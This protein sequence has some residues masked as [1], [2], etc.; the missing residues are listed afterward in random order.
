MGGSGRVWRAC[1]VSGGVGVRK[2]GV[3][4]SDL[5][6]A[7]FSSNTCPTRTTLPEL[8]CTEQTGKEPRI[9][10]TAPA[11]YRQHVSFVRCKPQLD[12]LSDYPEYRDTKPGIRTSA[13]SGGFCSSFYSS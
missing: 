5:A 11:G 3:T 2:G 9:Q 12:T 6:K 13:S 8:L 10:A 1:L 7:H 4:P